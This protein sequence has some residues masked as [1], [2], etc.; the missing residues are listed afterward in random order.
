MRVVSTTSLWS[1]RP[2]RGCEPR[3]RQGRHERRTRSSEGVAT[4]RDLQRTDRAT[5]RTVLTPIPSASDK[6]ATEGRA[7]RQLHAVSVA[8]FDD[9]AVARQLDLWRGILRY[10]LPRRT[11]RRRGRT[12][13]WGGGWCFGS[14]LSGAALTILGF[15]HLLLAPE[16]KR[17]ITPLDDGPCSCLS[18]V[19][20]HHPVASDRKRLR[21]SKPRL[22]ATPRDEP[23]AAIL[24]ESAGHPVCPPVKRSGMTDIAISRITLGRLPLSRQCPNASDRPL[25]GSIATDSAYVASGCLTA[26]AATHLTGWFL[27]E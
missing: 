19:R 21:S 9:L 26:V 22:M 13:L 25:R 4:G 1:L 12:G 17:A 14:R 2:G 10:R 23:C 27:L 11:S 20:L 3:L 8:G 5:A 6:T 7:V 16:S 18:W 24:F 15:H